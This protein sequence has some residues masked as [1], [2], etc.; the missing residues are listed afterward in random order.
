MNEEIQKLFDQ[1]RVQIKTNENPTMNPYG[2]Y[3]SI[4]ALN[5]LEEAV[6]KALRDVNR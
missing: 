1:L 4:G 6:E 5:K 3:S 2:A